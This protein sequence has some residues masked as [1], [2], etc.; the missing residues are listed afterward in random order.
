MLRLK[1][2]DD[3]HKN[4]DFVRKK[5]TMMILHGSYNPT[6]KRLCGLVYDCPFYG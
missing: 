3:S 4:K 5:N 6:I 2:F 1:L